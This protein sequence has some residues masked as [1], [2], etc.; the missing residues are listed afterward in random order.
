MN[1]IIDDLSNL[2]ISNE[3]KTDL[4]N[5]QK[6]VKL[7]IEFLKGLGVENYQSIFKAYYPM[8]LMDNSNFQ[9]IFNK[10]DIADLVDKLEK[11]M[12]IIEHL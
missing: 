7:N 1:N 4:E 9:E 2:S 10:Y 3:L 8:F 5:N 12:T 11:N 6:L